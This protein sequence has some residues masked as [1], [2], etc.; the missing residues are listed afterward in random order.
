MAQSSKIHNYDNHLWTSLDLTNPIDTKD[1]ITTLSN[2]DSDDLINRAI[3]NYPGVFILFVEKICLYGSLKMLQM[4]IIDLNFSII[5][6]GF[7]VNTIPCRDDDNVEMLCYVL[8]RFDRSVDH[9]YSVII[10][11][12]AVNDNVKIFK[13][14]IESIKDKV[15][16]IDYLK[17]IFDKI[18]INRSINI[19]RLLCDKGLMSNLL[20][21]KENVYLINRYMWNIEKYRDMMEILVEY[22]NSGQITGADDDIEQWIKVYGFD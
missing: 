12:A 17:K 1:F 9:Y 2:C 10:N 4:A 14:T 21:D 22:Y 6:P 18:I 3:I 11:H 19:W 13:F 5:S 8:E 7:F 16:I 20:C 15:T